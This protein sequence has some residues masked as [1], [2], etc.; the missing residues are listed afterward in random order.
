[1]KKASNGVANANAK[2]E[3]RRTH[4]PF[5][6]FYKPFQT[7]STIFHPFSTQKRCHRH[8]AAAYNAQQGHSHARLCQHTAERSLHRCE[9]YTDA[10]KVSI[11]L[12]ISARR[13]LPNLTFILL[14]S[15]FYALSHVLPFKMLRISRLVYLAR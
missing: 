7:F 3:K 5:L 11:C 6:A 9:A 1:M 13:C 4:T 2:A 8:S 12:V 15:Y 10:L 14:L